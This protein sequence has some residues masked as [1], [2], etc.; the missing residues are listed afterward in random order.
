MQYVTGDVVDEVMADL[1][2][3][4][5]QRLRPS[6]EIATFASA[7]GV[8]RD[9]VS[10]DTEDFGCVLLRLS[11]GCSGVV[12][13]SQ[14]SAGRKNSLTIEID[15]SDA[16]FSWNQEDPNALW[17]GHR[18]EPNRLVHRDPSFLDGAASKFS[19]LPAGHP[20]GWLDTLVN[21]F[22]DFYGAI[23]A[24]SEGA[25]YRPSF[26]SFSEAHRIVQTVEAVLASSRLG[27]PVRVGEDR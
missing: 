6:A 17:V 22:A 11:S 13:V 25:D 23:A 21:L 19:R 5:E 24:K 27:R 14:V 4:H 2:R 18:G 9:V 8:E 15:T 12:T 10:I 3:L 16:A 26:A 7:A 1:G 20:E